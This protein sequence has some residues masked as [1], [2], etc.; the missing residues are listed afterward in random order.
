[1]VNDSQ[2]T[3]EYIELILEENLFMKQTL[4]KMR[5]I[6]SPFICGGSQEVGPDNLPDMIMVCPALGADGFAIYKKHR[7]YDAP[8]Y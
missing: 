2:I 5:G 1:M 8:G 3:A 7:D 4:N 6:N